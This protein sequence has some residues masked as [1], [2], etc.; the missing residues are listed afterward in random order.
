MTSEPTDPRAA[1]KLVR[2]YSLEAAERLPQDNDAHFLAQVLKESVPESARNIISPWRRFFD[3]SPDE[4]P[5][6]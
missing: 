3:P 1:R 2:M 6:P 5:K 4:R